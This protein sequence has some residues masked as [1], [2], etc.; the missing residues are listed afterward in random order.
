M[1]E[2]L[3]SRNSIS[4]P[5]ILGSPCQLPGGC[6]SL[7]AARDAPRITQRQM[8]CGSGPASRAMT[9]QDDGASL[10]DSTV[11]RGL[12]EAKNKTPRLGHLQDFPWDFTRNGN[13]LSPRW[14]SEMELPVPASGGRAGTGL[15]AWR[16]D[17]QKQVAL[18]QVAVGGSWMII[19]TLQQHC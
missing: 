4:P 16:K 12:H 3:S 8:W 1:A 18:P 19:H 6:P 2:G 5:D 9:H 13:S 10:A 17:A 7:M 11:L 15:R 14:V